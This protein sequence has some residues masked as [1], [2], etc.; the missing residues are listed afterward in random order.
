MDITRQEFDRL[1]RDVHDLTVR[2]TSVQVRADE[3]LATRE[4]VA[5]IEDKITESHNALRS[6]IERQEHVVSG[7]AKQVTAVCATQDNLLKEKANQERSAFEEM[8][9][10]QGATFIV[11]HFVAP[12]LGFVFLGIQFFEKVAPYL[13]IGLP[14]AR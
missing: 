10:R 14:H 5:N 4:L 11:T 1:S 2:V 8:Q 9:K 12:L 3:V 13:G 7:I 6:S